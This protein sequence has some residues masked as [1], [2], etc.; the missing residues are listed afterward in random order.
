MCDIFILDN[1][2]KIVGVEL[3]YLPDGKI[4]TEHNV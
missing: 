3:P 2:I 4:E 1:D